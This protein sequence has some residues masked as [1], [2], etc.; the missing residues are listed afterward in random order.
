MADAVRHSALGVI[1]RHVSVAR[2]LREESQQLMRTA[3]NMSIQTTRRDTTAVGAQEAGALPP[4]G[5]QS[6]EHG[7]R[8]AN[9]TITYAGP[10]ITNDVAFWTLLALVVL[11]VSLW[12]GCYACIRLRASLPEAPSDLMYVHVPDGSPVLAVVARPSGANVSSVTASNA[13]DRT[14]TFSS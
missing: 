1:T 8:H 5:H 4:R 10:T 7:P 2:E 13:L 6:L 12:I 14:R 3:A 9:S 11:V